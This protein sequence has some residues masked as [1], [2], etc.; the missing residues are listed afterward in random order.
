MG[1]GWEARGHGHAGYRAR[2]GRW[3]GAR[4]LLAV[5]ASLGSVGCATTPLVP[6]VVDRAQPV[7]GRGLSVVDVSARTTSRGEVYQVIALVEAPAAEWSGQ[8]A[9]TLIRR[10]WFK[11]QARL[12][13]APRYVE[14]DT[15]TTAFIGGWGNIPDLVYGTARS[16]M[17]GRAYT[18]RSGT[19]LF[20]VSWHEPWMGGFFPSLG[21]VPPGDYLYD[22]YAV[23]GEMKVTDH[24]TR[25]ACAGCPTGVT[26][27]SLRIDSMHWLAAIPIR[28]LPGG[29]V[30]LGDAGTSGLRPGQ[31]PAPAPAPQQGPSVADRLREIKR[32]HDE[33]VLTDE[34]FRVKRDALMNQL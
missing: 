7:G 16:V 20:E 14:A 28:V 12:F 25:G 19:L 8:K 5:L 22:L 29:A 2:R 31:P 33:G 32:L 9:L 10:D 15:G 34:E 30:Q 27:D 23:A 21:T 26:L 11:T 4:L 13:E 3:S 17:N 6:V 18:A 1:L 24:G